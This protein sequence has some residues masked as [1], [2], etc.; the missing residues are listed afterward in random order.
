M[1]NHDGFRDILM[2]FNHREKLG[3]VRIKLATL[4]AGLLILGGA[5]FGDEKNVIQSPPSEKEDQ[6]PLWSND[7]IS[8]YTLGSKIIKSQNFGS[9]SV[10]HYEIEALRDVHLS[11]FR[12]ERSWGIFS[13][14][15]DG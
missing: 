3:K 5:A 14:L 2:K 7:L 1:G 11:L 13:F 15:L 8:D 12:R 9:Q 4:F 6:A 10:Y